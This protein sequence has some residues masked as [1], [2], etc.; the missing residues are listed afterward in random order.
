MAR[1]KLTQ[2]HYLSVPNVEWEHRET[3]TTNGRQ[4]RKVFIVP[5][6]LDPVSPSNSQ[7]P[8]NYGSDYI[9]AW[10]GKGNPADIVFIGDPTPDME[11]LDEEAKAVSDSLRD[12]WKHPIESLSNEGYGADLI[13][14]FEKQITDALRL[15]KPSNESV[16]GAEVE[17]LKAQI[18]ELTAQNV[19]IMEM[20]DKKGA[21]RV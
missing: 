13:R 21:R 18:A 12:T 8:P 10:E 4:V 9:V 17:A 15:G 19:R 11:P 2:P 5:I 7:Q 6:V 14:T 20:L 1:W 3:D 16:P